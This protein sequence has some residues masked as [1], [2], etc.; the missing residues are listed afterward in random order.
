MKKSPKDFEHESK[1]QK[2]KIQLSYKKTKE[3]GKKL[4]RT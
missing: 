4:K 3:H 2:P 1:R